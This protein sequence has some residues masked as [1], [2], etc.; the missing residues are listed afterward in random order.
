MSALSLYKDGIIVREDPKKFNA[1]GLVEL[2]QLFEAASDADPDFSYAYAELAYCSVRLS[3]QGWTNDF[4]ATLK[5]AEELANKAIDIKKAKENKDNFH[6]RWSLAMVK[7]NQGKFA[8]S[9]T[10]YGIAENLDPAID[11][12]GIPNFVE[13]LRCDL[14]ADRG[15]ALIYAG[16]HDDAKTQIEAAYKQRQD[17]GLAIPHWYPW[18]YARLR[19]MTGDYQ[20]AI[21]LLAGRVAEPNDVLLITAASKAQLGY[22]DSAMTYMA[23]FSANDPNWS[24]AKAAERYFRYDSDRQHWVEGLRK[25]GLK[26]N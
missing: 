24:I 13:E 6:G 23:Q 12:I 8:E 7:W 21:E 1:A 11:G 22:L 14:I 18:N 2:R 16:Q 17:Q 4:D 3:Q 5:R 9:L 15:E 10:E 19:Y 26:E 20:G 25:A